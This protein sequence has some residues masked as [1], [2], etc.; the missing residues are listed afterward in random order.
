MKLQQ[1][2][3]VIR[4]R[5]GYSLSQIAKSM[6]LS[7]ATLSQWLT[8]QYPG[9]N[10]KIDKAAKAFIGRETER[11][12]RPKDSF[13]FMLTENA[14]K[15]FETAR[16]CHIDCEIGVVVGDAGTGKTIAAQEYAKRNPDV[17]LIESDL[18]YTTKVLFQELHRQCGFSGIGTIHDMFEDVADKL[19]GSGRMIIVDEAENLPYKALDLLRRVYDKAGIGI[20]LIG[21]NRLVENLRGKRGEFKQLYSR[22]SLLARLRHLNDDDV[23][24]FVAQVFP[25]ANG[26]SEQFRDGARGSARTLVKLLHKSKRLSEINNKPLNQ[27][28]IK[29]A[30]EMLLI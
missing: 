14:A 8:G 21:L 28:I 4:E 2:V 5:K 29:K 16:L 18:S 7:A 6:N 12:A 27:A 3:N 26:L 19:R 20:I 9:N 13:D 15:I 10:D 22:V 11:S 17:I 23:N 24:Q 1:S 25:D 30:A